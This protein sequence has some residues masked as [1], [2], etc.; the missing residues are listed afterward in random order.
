MDF[1]FIFMNWWTHYG[2]FL[3]FYELMTQYE[4]FP[5]FQELIAC[6]QYECFLYFHELIWVH[7]FTRTHGFSMVNR[8]TSHEPVTI[9]KNEA[10]TVNKWQFKNSKSYF[11]KIREKNSHQAYM[12]KDCVILKIWLGFNYRG[13]GEIPHSHLVWHIRKKLELLKSEETNSISFTFEGKFEKLL[14][15]IVQYSI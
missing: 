8:I 13:G 3:H 5:H 1:S 9:T 2:Y 11:W 15:P 10:V 4:Y 14:K 6:T 12:K 7:F